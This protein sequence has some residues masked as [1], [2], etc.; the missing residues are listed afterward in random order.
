MI[1]EK[2]FQVRGGTGTGPFNTDFTIKFYF[3]LI[4]ILLIIWDIKKKDRLDYLRMLSTGTIMWSLAELF[5]QL[6][7]TRDFKPAYLFGWELP[8][9]LQLPLQGMVEGAMVAIV[10]M[11]FGD[12]IIDSQKKTYW[13]IGFI[14]LRGLLFWD[15]LRNGLVEPVYGGEVGVDITSRRSM[16]EPIPL[17]YLG[18]MVLIDVKFFRKTKREFPKLHKRGLMLMW[19]MIVF[20]SVWTLTEWIAGTRWIEQGTI[21]SSQHATPL[22][23][24]IFLTFDVVVEISLAYVPFI[25][26]PYL[27]GHIRKEEKQ[28]K[29]EKQEEIIHTSA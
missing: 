24:F 7:G 16:A 27:L 14:I 3:A 23:E 21:E 19:L 15:G 25:A 2:I 13:I 29:Q 11:F 6:S 9:Y 8:I 4:T 18:V 22:I 20:G 28:E 17:I 1:L 10:C 12:R 5:L 26:I